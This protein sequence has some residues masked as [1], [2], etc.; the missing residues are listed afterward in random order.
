[1]VQSVLEGAF[2]DGRYP[3]PCRD[4]HCGRDTLMS[5]MI[6]RGVKT[7]LLIAAPRTTVIRHWVQRRSVDLSAAVIDGV[8]PPRCAGCDRRGRWLCPDCEAAWE[9]FASPWCVRCGVPDHIACCCAD[10]P[11]TLH[12][13]RCLG[14]LDGW[15]HNA[16]VHLK[17]H[18]ESA[19]AG[20][21]G[22]LLGRSMLN[23]SPL[24]VDGIVPVPLHPR[25]V[26]ERGYNQ[27]E[28]LARRAA[29]VSGVPLVPVLHRVRDTPRQVGSTLA[30]RQSNVAG[31]FRADAR[32][33]AGM[34]LLVVDDVLTTGATVA[35]CADALCA[36]GATLV[37]V[38]TLA[39]QVG[40][41]I[42]DLTPPR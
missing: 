24:D 30:Q 19:R 37:S 17:Y 12:R 14:P 33:C 1:M 42:A 20:H 26:R 2:V 23:D 35:S 25:R 40:G 21:L 13:A 4:P 41:T 15:L 29:T 32:G 36:A 8:F 5:P 31:A 11:E 10:M 38:L 7:F 3:R 22:D 9:P 6:G 27:A 34:R 39:R 28:L 16:I 18:G